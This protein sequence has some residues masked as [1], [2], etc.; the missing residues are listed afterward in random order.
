MVDLLD[1]RTYQTELYDH[2]SLQWAWAKNPDYGFDPD[3]L[4]ERFRDTSG[5]GRRV[6]ALWWFVF[7]NLTLNFYP[8]GLSINLYEP[9]N[10]DPTK[11]KFVWQH[12]VMDEK[13]YQDCE[14]VW[15]NTKVDNEDVLAMNLV[16]KGIQSGFAPRGRFAP[17][18]EAGP[19]WFH[20]TVFEHLFSEFEV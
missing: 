8:W 2:A 13:K 4:P 7:P 9:L 10:D 19:H 6:I 18:E 16:R 1:Y 3:H 20:R 17:E 15:Q 12:Y 14:S 5:K 11:T